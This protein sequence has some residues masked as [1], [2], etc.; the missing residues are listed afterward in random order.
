MPRPPRLLDTSGGT[1]HIC[2][3]GNNKSAIFLEEQDFIY[4]EKIIAN[5]KKTHP[6]LLYNYCWMT[7]H[8][9]MLLSPDQK[10]HLPDLMQRINQTYARYFNKKYGRSGH[11][12]QGRYYSRLVDSDAYLIAC[13]HYIERNPVDAGIFTAAQDYR[14]SSYRHYALGETNPLVNENPAFLALG[15]NDSE[16]RRAYRAVMN[17]GVPASVEAGT[18][19]DITGP[20]PF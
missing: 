13:A 15:R 18:A 6:F 20:G 11:F 17:G 7:N 12:W 3:R 1:Y 9:H 10:T 4:F 2:C 8:T 5:L 14:W 16:R 19:V